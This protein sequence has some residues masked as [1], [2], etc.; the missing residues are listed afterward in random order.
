MWFPQYED[1]NAE[2]GRA[3]SAKP[4]SRTAEAPASQQHPWSV[5][6][7]VFAPQG[8]SWLHPGRITKIEQRKYYVRFEDGTAN[9]FDA[10][11]LRTFVL[12]VGSRVYCRWQ[13]G[14]VYYPGKIAQRKGDTYLIHYDDGDKEWARLPLMRIGV[15]SAPVFQEKFAKW[16]FGTI[17]SLAIGAVASVMGKGCN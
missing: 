9:W 11:Q 4:Q 13:G 5:G 17:I 2:A 10:I 16:I 8:V 7:R 3:S 12:D 14:D 6:D 15:G 1:N